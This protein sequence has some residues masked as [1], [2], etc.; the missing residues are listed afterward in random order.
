MPPSR[1]IGQVDRL[2]EKAGLR[3]VLVLSGVP[4]YIR[5]RLIESRVDSVVP[6]SQLFAPDFRMSLHERGTS[7]P[8][9]LSGGE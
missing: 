3:V 5:C 1:L 4:P 7:P 6:G 8:V 9:C 2:A